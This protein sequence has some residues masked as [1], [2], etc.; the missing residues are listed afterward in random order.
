[1]S[2]KLFIIAAFS[3]ASLISAELLA[4]E[5]YYG[6]LYYEILKLPEPLARRVLPRNE[7][8][9]GTDGQRAEWSKNKNKHAMQYRGSVSL[10]EA[11]ADIGREGWELVSATQV[12]KATTMYFKRTK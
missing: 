3:V 4:A 9:F 5:V 7:S 6:V 1:M 12:G 11:L 2:K 8:W 10:E